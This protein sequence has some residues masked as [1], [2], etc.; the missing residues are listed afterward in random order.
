LPRHR[1]STSDHPRRFARNE[2]VDDHQL[3]FAREIESA[4]LGAVIEAPDLKADD[5][6]AASGASVRLK[7]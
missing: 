2:H 7:N 4:G 6:I 1:S 3:E 5:L